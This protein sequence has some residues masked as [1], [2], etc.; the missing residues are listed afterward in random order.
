MREASKRSRAAARQALRSSSGARSRA[1]ASA[2]TSLRRC[3]VTP[4]STIS[5]TDP[6]GTAT[7][8]VPVASASTIT[9]PN[10][11]GHRRGFSR[12]QEPP[13]SSSLSRAPSSPTYSTAE[14]SS[15]LTAASK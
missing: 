8:G 4:S 5:G 9:R 15:G 2:G 1:A 11:S 6:T 12:A 10:G 14:H 13:S 3:P 7:T